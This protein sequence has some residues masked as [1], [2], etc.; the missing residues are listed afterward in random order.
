[1]EEGAEA[2]REGAKENGAQM[3]KGWVCRVLRGSTW[4]DAARQKDTPPRAMR[5]WQALGA[6]DA[7]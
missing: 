1:M 7:L 3:Q 5:A 6:R 4:Q 2:R